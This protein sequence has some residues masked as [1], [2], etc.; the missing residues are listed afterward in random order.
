MVKDIQQ[1]EVSED[2]FDGITRMLEVAS[3]PGR[4]ATP[5]ELQRTLLGFGRAA[6]SRM[7][8]KLTGIE[9]SDFR[10]QMLEKGADPTP[11]ERAALS[12]VLECTEG[13]LFPE[14]S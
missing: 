2:I 4:R 6:L 12:K 5:L 7:A 10:I 13:Y 11:E 14:G 8:E 3:M 9:I 1:V